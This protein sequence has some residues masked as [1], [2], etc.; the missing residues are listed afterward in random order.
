MLIFSFVPLIAIIFYS[1]AVLELKYT[2]EKNGSDDGSYA[3]LILVLSLSIMGLT[4]LVTL[5][6]FKVGIPLV[7]ILVVDA[8]INRLFAK[9]IEN[10]DE[11][12]I[13]EW[14]SRKVVTRFLMLHYH[15]RDHVR[16]V[17]QHIERKEDLKLK[18]G[19]SISYKSAN[20]K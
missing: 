18:I 12:T 7:C 8:V 5:Y 13:R 1:F 15:T 2:L 6:C 16:V 19:Q 11:S 4:S 14:C 10:R 3:K 9:A 20:G 17:L